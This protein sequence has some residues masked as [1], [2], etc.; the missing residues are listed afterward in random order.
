[1]EPKNQELNS[2][3]LVSYLNGLSSAN[4]DAGV[5]EL[6][7]VSYLKRNDFL[8]IYK[9]VSIFG[10]SELFFD[11]FARHPL[12]VQI[13]SNIKPLKK[14]SVLILDPGQNNN[15]GHHE[16][17]NLFYAEKAKS[18]N[19]KCQ[20]WGNCLSEASAQ[21][22]ELAELNSSLLTKVYGDRKDN[23]SISIRKNINKA[24]SDE[25]DFFFGDISP[26]EIIF[27]TACDYTLAGFLSWLSTLDNWKNIKVSICLMKIRRSQ[28]QQLDGDVRLFIREQLTLIQN[29][30]VKNITVHSQ[31]R[32]NIEFLGKE[33]TDL[34]ELQRL[35]YLQNVNISK[36]EVKLDDK[37]NFT[38]G[39]LGQTRE[40]KGI[41]ELID[42]LNE[43]TIPEYIRFIIQINKDDLRGISPI[44]LDKIRKII[45]IKSNVTIINGYQDLSRYYSIY[46]NLDAV[47]LPYKENYL[48][49]GS[50]ILDEAIHLEKVVFCHENVQAIIPKDVS[51]KIN[52]FEFGNLIQNI[53]ECIQK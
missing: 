37:K 43:N 47:I 16:N 5:R 14:G 6:A 9:Y 48:G 25:L 13:K 53:N 36:S 32:T 42:F 31:S 17:Y 49:R 20:I 41:L 30:K 39:F 29:E 2:S 1:M 52:F 22:T 46:H 50:G 33:F 40:E 11:V 15:G 18:E 35:P 4:R 38:I 34:I 51:K 28:N 3:K 24:F 45:E 27:H 44:H 23:F 21:L 26:S 12:I 19:N 8:N 7:S 10:L